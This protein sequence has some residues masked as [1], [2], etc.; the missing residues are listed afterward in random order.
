MSSKCPLFFVYRS[1]IRSYTAES[2]SRDDIESA[3]EVAQ[4]LMGNPKAMHSAR[5]TSF[6][7]NR[8]NDILANGSL[9]DINRM[10][11]ALAKNLRDN[12]DNPYKV[13]KGIPNRRIEPQ[14]ANVAN[15]QKGVQDKSKT[16]KPLN[17]FLNTISN[18]MV[19]RT[20]ENTLSAKCKYKGQ[21][22]SKANRVEKM[23]ANGERFEQRGKKF[24]GVTS[25]GDFKATMGEY[26]YYKYLTQ[27]KNDTAQKQEQNTAQPQQE[28]PQKKIDVSKEKSDV[29][30]D[31]TKANDEKLDKKISPKKTVENY[32]RNFVGQNIKNKATGLVANFGTT[33]IKKMLSNKAVNKSVANG[34]TPEQHLE[35]ARNIRE[36]FENAVLSEQHSD[37]KNAPS[38]K[39]ID[40]F[41][42][43]T[44]VGGEKA[45][46]KITVK[47]TLVDGN[48]IYSVELEA[49]EKPA[50]L[51]ENTRNS[52]S[53]GS[54]DSTETTGNPSSTNGFS[55]S[56]STSTVPQNQ[57]NVKE[58]KSIIKP[59]T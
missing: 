17:D 54:N 16:P 10:N 20:H 3:K 29:I 13:I 2:A 28:V 30:Q 6:S 36:L 21:N 53:T 15:V 33:G 41:R 8:L 51:N 4:I 58:K 1:M 52:Q 40:R 27:H 50:D 5:G 37:R 12:G 18:K 11:N 31:D 24:F 42:C 19:R 34:F 32:L 38:I 23:V 56:S 45:V 46:A 9:S 26:N 49:L 22:M 55:E 7:L 57:Q 43:D 48:K 47:E 59:K 35:A 14:P 44:N 39:A 25:E